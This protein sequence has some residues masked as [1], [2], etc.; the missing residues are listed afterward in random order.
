M[1]NYASPVRSVNLRIW[2]LKEGEL[3]WTIGK[4]VTKRMSTF[5]CRL[6][7]APRPPNKKKTRL[8]CFPATYLDCFSRIGNDAQSL[9]KRSRSANS[10]VNPQTVCGWSGRLIERMKPKPAPK[11]PRTNQSSVLRSRAIRCASSSR[12]SSDLLACSPAQAC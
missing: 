11:P 3:P 7:R 8:E 1:G 2:H 4:P 12:V 5:S 6:H 9:G 10:P